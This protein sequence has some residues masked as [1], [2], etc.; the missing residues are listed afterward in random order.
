MKITKRQLKR[1]IKE[2]LSRSSGNI[3]EAGAGR[4]LFGWMKDKDWE[5]EVERIETAENIKTIGDLKFVLDLAKLAKTDQKAEK[6]W[7]SFGTGFIADAL[8]GGLVKSLADVVKD[9]YEAPDEATGGTALAYL[10]VD[11]GI[12]KIVDDPIENAYLAELEDMIA[13]EDPETPLVDFDVTKGLANFIK[14]N[15]DDRTVTGWAGQQEGR[16]MKISKKTLKR[17]IKEEKARLLREQDDTTAAD[18]NTHH[19]PRVEWS[20]VSELID[21]W[22]EGEEKAF[23]KGDPSMMAM[24]DTIT[25]AKKNW[26]LQVDQAA[27]EMEAEM[28]DRVRAAALQTMQEY[29]DK[30]INGEYA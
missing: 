10:N 27:M 6:A 28:T 20:N 25:D 16:K 14:K 3:H 8:G 7:T 11:D 17:I 24:G 22:A 18:N 4:K 15:I 13:A 29:T 19:W 1:V 2:E 26:D 5:Q 21:K 9:T 23:D 30:L 12:A